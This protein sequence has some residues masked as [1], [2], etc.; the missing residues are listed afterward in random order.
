VVGTVAGGG[1]GGT[2]AANYG[3]G[4]T[5]GSGPGG[6]GGGGG[7]YAASGGGG[8]GGGSGGGENTGNQGGNGGGPFAGT[9]G[10]CASGSSSNSGVNGGYLTAAGNGDV[11]TDA[12]LEIGSGG[13]G[14]GSTTSGSYGG[15]GGGGGAGGGRIWLRAYTAL[16]ITASGSVVS[17][18]SGGGQ[19]G[20][21]T[22]SSSY[23]GGGS[24][25]GILL[26]SCTSIT[27][28]GTVDNRGRQA[29]TLATANGGTVKLLYHDSVSVSGS[30]Q[31][32]RLFDAGPD[33]S[34]L[35]C[36][37]E[38]TTPVLISPHAVDV[39]VPTPTGAASIG[40]LWTQCFDPE[41]FSITY[42]LELAKDALFTDI[43]ASQV[44]LSINETSQ[45]IFLTGLPAT[46]FWRVRARDLQ[47]Q[48]GAWST[49]GT[50][51]V[52]L[53][54]GVNHGAKDCS[55]S[56]GAMGVWLAP[57][58]LGFGLIGFGLRRRRKA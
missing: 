47:G 33:S 57:A 24:G 56:V 20:G 14:G 7:G 9:G 52:V 36:N 45:V 54:D 50:F 27:V 22:F 34:S 44:D 12:S 5:G 37:A 10:Q 4:G 32:G 58:L 29:N 2:S 35:Q 26:D 49:T 18:G 15:G 55:I 1:N 42:E 31:T 6:G 46:K 8:G 25:G 41:G 21:P 38:P 3:Q 51:R 11:S 16:T 43:E 17:Q 48:E 39:G 40:F 23:G 30:I 13:G 19:F 28:A 53:D